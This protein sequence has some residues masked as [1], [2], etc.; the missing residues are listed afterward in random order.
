MAT[1]YRANGITREVH[2]ANGEKFT[3]NELQDH[4]GG[5]I[6]NMPVHPKRKERGVGYLCNEDGIGLML[7]PNQWMTMFLGYVC[8][9]DI[10]EIRDEEW[11][12]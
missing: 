6:E 2:P 11:N 8:V 10:L 7:Q 5:L 3:L 1:L 9:G 12:S 4:V